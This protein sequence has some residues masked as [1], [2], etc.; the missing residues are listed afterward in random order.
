MYYNKPTQ[1]IIETNEELSPGICYKNEVINLTSGKVFSVDD[2]I[3]HVENEWC[4]L[5]SI[6]SEKSVIV[7]H[8]VLLRR[9]TTEEINQ[10]IAKGADEYWIPEYTFLNPMPK[11]GEQVLLRT[12]W[13]TDIDRCVV[14]NDGVLDIYQLDETVTWDGVTEWA[15]LPE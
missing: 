2:V 8:K 11:D 4:P 10:Y 7:W 14:T 12:A 6:S 1:V 3:I 5:T 13:G 15:Y 9:L